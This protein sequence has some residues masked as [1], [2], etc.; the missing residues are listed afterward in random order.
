MNIKSLLKNVAVK[1]ENVND[2]DFKIPAKRQKRILAKFPE[3]RDDIERSYFQYCCQ[4]CYYN[5]F[6]RVLINI[7]SAPLVVLFWI[8]R[9]NPAEKSQCDAIFFADGK[10]DT[11]IPEELRNKIGF[12]KTIDEKKE[13]LTKKDRNFFLGLIKRY[14]LSFHFLLKCLLKLRFYSYEI[15]KADP[16]YIIVCNE[17]SFTSSFMT[18]YCEDNG[19]AHINVMHGEKYFYI[20][21]SFFRFNECYVWDSYYIDLFKELRVEPGQFKTAVPPSLKI[22]SDAGKDCDYTYYLTVECGEKIKRIITALKQISQKG[23][24]T[25]VRPHPRYS[26]IKE[27]RMLADGIEIEDSNIISIDD[28]LGRTKN[29]VSLYST[30][31][32]QAYNSNVGIVIDDVSDPK[33]FSLLDEFEYIML[34]KEHKLL[35]DILEELKCKSSE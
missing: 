16:K 27:I 28:S 31:L 34:K 22:H 8:K 2:N 33:R 35:S 1:L 21:D 29:A 4:M 12:I 6:L 14:P 11:I 26:N 18:R 32:N 30:V 9:N 20:R 19:I 17:Y 5:A 13:Y 15:Q 7:V 24:R 3:P 23:Y 25:A 10:P